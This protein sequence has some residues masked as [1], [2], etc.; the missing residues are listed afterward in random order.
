MTT[1]FPFSMFHSVELRQSW[2]LITDSITRSMSTLSNTVVI[3]YVGLKKKEILDK[4]RYYC[5]SLEDNGACLACKRV[6]RTLGKSLKVTME[7]KMTCLWCWSLLVLK[8]VSFL[9]VFSHET[10]TTC[11][12]HPKMTEL[13]QSLG[14]DMAVSFGLNVSWLEVW[15]VVCQTFVL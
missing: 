5:F 9:C 13:Y 10:Q 8:S 3:Q 7:N 6:W 14:K 12:D 11:W 4:S 2:P 15:F 1:H